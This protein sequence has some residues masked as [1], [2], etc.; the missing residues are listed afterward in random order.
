MSRIYILCSHTKSG[1]ILP[2]LPPLHHQG[3]PIE[4]QGILAT[5]PYIPFLTT[6][7]VPAASLI[8]TCSCKVGHG[9]P[10]PRHILAKGDLVGVAYQP[11]N[12]LSSE[13]GNHLAPPPHPLNKKPPVVVPSG[14]KH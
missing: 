1:R 5:P 14:S 11:P 8:P 2:H 12:L 10:S 13:G 6:K 9:S 7:M 3:N 4:L